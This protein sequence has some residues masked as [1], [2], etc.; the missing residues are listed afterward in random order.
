MVTFNGKPL[1]DWREYFAQKFDDDRFVVADERGNP[2]HRVIG[3][4]TGR[5][6]TEITMW[7]DDR[8]RLKLWAVRFS[9][10]QSPAWWLDQERDQSFDQPSEFNLDELELTEQWLDVPLRTG[11]IEELEF[12][13]D[14]HV[15]SRVYLH[16]GRDDLRLIYMKQA[17]GCLHSA[18]LGL[19]F[20]PLRRHEMRRE[21]VVIPPMLQT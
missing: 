5:S 10:P 21:R 2:D 19:V 8:D 1:K 11:W 6:Q 17:T 4:R 9:N 15:R 14:E 3:D 16:P 20:Y 12:L 7:W 13:G 18:Y